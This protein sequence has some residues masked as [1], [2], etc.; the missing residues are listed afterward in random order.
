MSINKHTNKKYIFTSTFFVGCHSF[1]AVVNPIKIGVFQFIVT[2][3][4]TYMVSILSRH[5]LAN[6]CADHCRQDCSQCDW[7]GDCWST[8]TRLVETRTSPHSRQIPLVQCGSPLIFVPEPH[9]KAQRAACGSRA[10]VCQP[11]T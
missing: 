4:V 9:L 6:T 8:P 7:N 5:L 2:S 3:K 11:L 10:A 1:M